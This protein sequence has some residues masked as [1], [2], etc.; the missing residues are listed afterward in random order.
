MIPVNQ[1]KIFPPD[2]PQYGNSFQACIASILEKDITEIPDLGAALSFDWVHW[3]KWLKENNLIS[4]VLNIS[5]RYII[6]N[7]DFLDGGIIGY[8]IFVVN[9]VEKRSAI[10]L[11]K[12]RVIHDP[13]TD[14]H[15]AEKIINSGLFV[16]RRLDV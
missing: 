2:H 10:I 15:P 6:I 9:G 14:K 3:A 7:S 8:K 16:G 12:G 5:P 11:E 4:G 13:D 1:T